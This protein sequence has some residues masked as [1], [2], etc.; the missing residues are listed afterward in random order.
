MTN[1]FTWVFDIIKQF[2]RIFIKIFFLSLFLNLLGLTLPLVMMAITDRVIVYQGFNTLQIL[3]IGLIITDLFEILMSFIRSYISAHSSISI[4][5]QTSGKI[6][7][8]LLQ[9]KTQYFD[10]RSTGEVMNRLHEL[11]GIKDFFIS[12][13][14]SIL[15]D[16]IFAI[17]FLF[18]LLS[19]EPTLSLITL[20]AVPA[21]M[22]ITMIDIKVRK[23]YLD[24]QFRIAMI[25]QSLMIETI[26]LIQTVKSMSIE[27]QLEKLW[28]SQITEGSDISFKLVKIETYANA[29]TTFVNK[30]SSALILYI[31]ST[32]V[33]TGDITF[34]T[35]LAFNAFSSYVISPLIEF[36][37]L[38]KSLQQLSLSAERLKEI[39]DAPCETKINS[40]GTINQNDISGEVIFNNV[41]FSYQ[42]LQTQCLKN[43]NFKINAGEI[44][45][46]TG[47]SGS[48]KSTLVKLM[49]GLYSPNDGKILLDNHDINLI[50][51]RKFIGCVQQDSFLF[52]RTIAENIAIGKPNAT[53]LEIHH[54]AEMAGIHN[55]IESLPSGY[56]TTVEEKG[57]NFSGGQRQ[58]IAI[59]RSLMLN[60]RV[61]IFD[62]ATSALDYESE[63]IIH[64]NMQFIAKNRTVII[65][66]HRLEV[67]KIANRILVMSDGKISEEFNDITL[68]LK[69][70]DHS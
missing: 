33:M 10:N 45:G 5:L 41:S 36:A 64:S 48:G 50:N 12:A 57:Q 40:L 20:L 27:S 61:L 46:I 31:G 1:I 28:V 13:P 7:N 70:R 35:L 37:T 56:N 60:P 19:I 62:E 30:F 65:I 3:I 29:A 39:F 66:S 15:I 21:H 42:G 69:Q 18:V 6:Y 51:M 58:R 63:K 25:N 49:Q 68:F 14:I 38:R 2:K 23:H 55:F 34:G 4:T 53:L 17:I 47:E 24:E 32:K 8:K 59:A 44:I 43:I 26:S 9:I 52:S 67:F 11:D 22:L 54:A 16:L